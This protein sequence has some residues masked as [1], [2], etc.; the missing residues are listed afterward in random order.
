MDEDEEH[1][2]PVYSPVR[3][4][5]APEPGAGL[6]CLMTLA[7]LCVVIGLGTTC[8]PEYQWIVN[9]FLAAGVCSLVVIVPAWW[10]AIRQ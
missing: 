10:R 6:G 1:I 3:Y 9:G 7:I 4:H 8:P 5:Y 2:A